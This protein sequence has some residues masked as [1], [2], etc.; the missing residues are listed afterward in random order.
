MSENS[1]S[2]GVHT[3]H[4]CLELLFLPLST[5]SERT[6]F[7]H[8]PSSSFSAALSSSRLSPHLRPS[9]S[10]PS[11]PALYQFAH[12]HSRRSHFH[13]H[14]FSTSA[15]HTSP[16][17]QTTDASLFFR[18]HTSRA[19]LLPPPLSLLPHP[20]L[21]R[22]IRNPSELLLHLFPPF[23]TT[24]TLEPFRSTFRSYLATATISFH[25]LASASTRCLTHL[26]QLYDGSFSLFSTSSFIFSLIPHLLHFEFFFF[27]PCLFLFPF[28]SIFLHIQS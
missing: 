26:L 20:Y 21:P 24:S 22:P 2:C 7:V 25:P 8:S 14:S 23:S 9:L 16:V 13:C 18:F 11:I 15:T 27:L 28:L 1:T 4:T 12:S 17:S 10:C 5:R 6:S 19:I 3:S